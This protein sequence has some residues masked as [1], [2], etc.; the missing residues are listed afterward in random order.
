MALCFT[1]P[2]SGLIKPLEYYIKLVWNSR[3]FP[4]YVRNLAR[5][6]LSLTSWFWV[7][8]LTRT[9]VPSCQLVHELHN[10][11]ASHMCR[12]VTVTKQWTFLSIQGWT[13]DGARHV[14][15]GP[16]MKGLSPYHLE[17]NWMGEMRWNKALTLVQFLIIF[18]CHLMCFYWCHT[19]W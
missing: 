1:R 7:P 6:I 13:C 3:V 4:L 15:T 9:L 5:H 11:G 8:I 16:S 2:H 10:D 14:C 17:T 18:C 12:S 19:L